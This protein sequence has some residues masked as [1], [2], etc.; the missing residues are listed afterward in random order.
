MCQQQQGDAMNPKDWTLLIIAA[1][2]NKALQPVQLQKALFLLG[3][4]LSSSQLRADRFYP[5]QAYDYGPFCS[6]IYFDAERLRDEGLVQIDRPI[7]SSYRVYS[8]TEQGSAAAARLRAALDPK[9]ASYLDETVAWV[10]SLS[11][12]QLITWVYRQFPEM[13][14]NS[15]FQE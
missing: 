15:V 12:R 14:V 11:F 7:P 8:A 2:R 10:T 5:F 1:A 6:E 3:K 4:A 9:V 13:R